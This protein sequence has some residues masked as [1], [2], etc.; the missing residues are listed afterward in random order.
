MGAQP[1]PGSGR[2][3]R[4]AVEHVQVRARRA[5]QS[6]RAGRRWRVPS[7]ATLVR[8]TGLSERTVRTCLDRLEAEGII[9][10]CDPDV[11]AARI[12][13]ADRRPLGWNL[14]LSLV[15]DLADKLGAAAPEGQLSARQSL[16]TE[17]LRRVYEGHSGAQPSHLAANPV[18][19]STGGVQPTRPAAGTRCN[20]RG[21]GVQPVQRRGGAVAP[22][23]YVEPSLEPSAAHARAPDPT[24]TDA[25]SDRG[26]G[27]AEFFA[28]LGDQRPLTAAQQSRLVPALMS[29][30]TGGWTPLALAGWAAANTGGVRS[31][32]A[33]L[34]SRLSPAEL[35]EPKRQRPTRLPWCG[36]CDEVTRQAFS[37]GSRTAACRVTAAG[38]L[39]GSRCSA[40]GS[41]PACGADS[42]G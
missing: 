28:A 6:R 18:D 17:R 10:P 36:Y 24:P 23:P 19:K 29:A 34:A 3:R 2:S 9:A 27:V 4:P 41:A 26:G 21:D 5:G 7:V 25:G 12:K 20:Q 31:P 42:Q 37:S 30:L 16:P 40:A 8:Y 33:V 1:R 11:V 13:R 35:P 38:P 15:H 14:N 22:E 32:Y 39:C